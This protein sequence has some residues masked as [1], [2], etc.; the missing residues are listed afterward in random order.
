MKHTTLNNALI[1]L[2]VNLEI[3]GIAPHNMNYED[4]IEEN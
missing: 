3:G 4:G 1:A 2:N